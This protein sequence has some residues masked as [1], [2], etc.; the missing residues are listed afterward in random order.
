LGRRGM[1]NFEL[2]LF[3]STV[4]CVTYHFIVYEYK[5][6]QRESS[7]SEF[8]C[9]WFWT[10]AKKLLN[11]RRNCEET[12]ARCVRFA[13]LLWIVRHFIAALPTELVWE[14]NS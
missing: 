3:L 13:E 14:K 2:L 12:E 11:N 5:E 8:E 7:R 10:P 4:T 9:V 6:R 1:K